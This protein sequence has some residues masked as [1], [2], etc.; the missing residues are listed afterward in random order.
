MKKYIL[1][2]DLD[3]TL[4]HTNKNET[5]ILRPYLKTFIKNMSKYMYLVIYT[6][7]L[8]T[9]ADEILKKHKLLDYFDLK[10][11]RNSLVLSDKYGIYTKDLNYVIKKIMHYKLKK[12]INISNSLL[13]KNNKINLDNIIFID[14][15]AENC[16]CQPE[17]SIV[18]KDYIGDKNDKGLRCLNKFLMDLIKY[19]ISD[20][21]T[22]LK[23]NLWQIQPYLK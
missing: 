11:Y 10:L 4:F 1:V 22:Y 5:T 18:V 6:A 20:V 12:K 15:L 21:Q 2:L 9:Y 13:V 3:E 19:N 7:A 8:K 14:N 23:Y 17:N 16:V